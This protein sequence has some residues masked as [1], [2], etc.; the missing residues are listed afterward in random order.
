MRIAAARKIESPILYS[1][2]AALGNMQQA[3]EIILRQKDCSSWE[4]W[5][6]Q[7]EAWTHQGLIYDSIDEPY[8]ALRAFKKSLEMFLKQNKLLAVGASLS[9]SLLSDIPGDGDYR[10]AG[11]AHSVDTTFCMSGLSAVFRHRCFAPNSILYR[12]KHRI[13]LIAFLFKVSQVYSE[14]WHESHS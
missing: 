3:E 12:C 11:N 9:P 1:Q 8:L 4:Y 14:R 13:D 2:N 10:V 7:S 6:A 5:L